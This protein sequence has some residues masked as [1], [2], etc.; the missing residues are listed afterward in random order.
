M[1]YPLLKVREKVISVN[2][3]KGSMNVVF[4]VIS[5]DCNTSEKLRRPQIKILCFYYFILK[6]KYYL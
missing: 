2:M 1:F 5:L 6:N 3:K 4:V